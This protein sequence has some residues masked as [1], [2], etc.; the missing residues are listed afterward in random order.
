[1]VA[2]SGLYCRIVLLAVFRK[3]KKLPAGDIRKLLIVLVELFGIY[4]LLLFKA[5]SVRDQL[6]MAC[7][8]LKW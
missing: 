7:S 2:R 5:G 8:L 4:R 3:Y 1:M 6:L